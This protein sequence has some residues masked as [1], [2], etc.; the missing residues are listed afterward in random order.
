MRA[1]TLAQMPKKLKTQVILTSLSFIH[2]RGFDFVQRVKKL[3]IVGLRIG[4]A[5]GGENNLEV[6]G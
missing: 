5:T 6:T 4:S 3:N 1:F 2:L